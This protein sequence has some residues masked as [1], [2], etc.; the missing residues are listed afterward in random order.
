MNVEVSPLAKKK[1]KGEGKVA[2]K[3][4]A[5]KEAIVMASDAKQ[6]AHVMRFDD[7]NFVIADQPRA[8]NMVSPYFELCRINFWTW[9]ALVPSLQVGYGLKP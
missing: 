7:V 8:G 3:V 1:A 4:A 6:L 2:G 5:D 9:F